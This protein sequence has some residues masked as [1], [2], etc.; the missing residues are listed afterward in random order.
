MPRHSHSFLGFLE[1]ECS[2]P[3][4]LLQ[5]N[6][7]LLANEL[8]QPYQGKDLMRS[9]RHCLAFQMLLRFHSFWDFPEAMNLKLDELRLEGIE[10]PNCE[11][12]QPCLEKD[13]RQGLLAYQRRQHFHSSLSFLAV[14]SLMLDGPQLACTEQL[15][16]ELRQ[17][18]LVKG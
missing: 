14:G 11:L 5:V 1:V 8:K 2:K 15:I 10:K 3:G 4:E 13:L 7:N 12:V 16:H 18:S 9:H 17:P 6:T